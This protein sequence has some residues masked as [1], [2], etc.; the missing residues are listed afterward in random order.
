MSIPSCADR[1]PS[2][3][4]IIRQEIR[5]AVDT[6]RNQRSVDDAGLCREAKD[7]LRIPTIDRRGEAR[8][9]PVAPGSRRISVRKTNHRL[10]EAM[11]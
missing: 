11:L 9:V 5:L 1:S 3:A 6:G 8:F 10:W 4:S 7:G 2:A